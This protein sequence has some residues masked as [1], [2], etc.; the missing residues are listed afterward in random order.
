M[1]ALDH[2][3]NVNGLRKSG[4]KLAVEIRADLRT[5]SC[6]QPNAREQNG[7]VDVLHVFYTSTVMRQPE[8]G[9]VR[10]SDS[11]SA[12]E[13][14][15]SL[16]QAEYDAYDASYNPGI[17]ILPLTL[18]FGTVVHIWGYLALWQ[19]TTPQLSAP[20]WETSDYSR[21]RYANWANHETEVYR[22]DG[23]YAQFGGSMFT[24]RSGNLDVEW[25]NGVGWSPER[26]CNKGGD[27]GISECDYSGGLYSKR[28]E[29]PRRVFYDAN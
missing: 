3:F 10:S 7:M 19:L 25:K 9:T 26:Q 24:L 17:A 28:G 11:R 6:V 21:M 29:E 12:S 4:A 2:A 16:Q 8:R 22:D 18:T 5:G 27:L 23:L 14:T 1:R 20:R 13:T 15:A